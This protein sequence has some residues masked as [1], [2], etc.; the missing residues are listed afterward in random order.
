[1]NTRKCP[2]CSNQELLKNQIADVEIDIC[3]ECSGIWFDKGELQSFLGNEYDA[4]NIFSILN[5][6]GI[7]ENC[8]VCKT[9][10]LE[11]YQ[12]NHGNFYINLERCSSC[13]GIWLDKGELDKIKSYLDYTKKKRLITKPVVLNNRS[14]ENLG[15]PSLN[16]FYNHYISHR[17]KTEKYQNDFTASMYFFSLI[18]QIPFELEKNRKPAPL[19]LYSIIFF[20]SFISLYAL[21]EGALNMLQIFEDYSLIP[22][23]I[24]QF[25]MF[26]FLTYNFLHADIMHLLLNVYIIWVFGDNVYYAMF[27][28]NRIITAIKF[29]SFLLI[30]GMIGGITHY[31]ISAVSGQALNVP[32]VGASGMASA[33]LA[34]Y[35]RLYPDARIFQVILFIPFRFSM[36][37]YTLLWFFSNVFIAAVYG[38]RASISWQ[39]HIGSFIAGI[40]LI[41]LF[42]SKEKKHEIRTS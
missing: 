38:V 8:P 20:I 27:K 10:N 6:N 32:V 41:N 19:T 9:N 3:P 37:N 2:S 33:L 5:E 40:L 15:N 16:D 30:G 21:T 24:S 25:E 12:Y 18:L 4:S 14:P 35:W 17:K 28:D 7:S 39:C 23:K 13:D 29:C 22:Q 36:M 42:I 1:M 26:R 31:V 34:A 11:V